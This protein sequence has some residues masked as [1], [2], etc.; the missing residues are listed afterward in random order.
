MATLVGKVGIVMKG[1]W[2]NASTYET[3]DAVS[4]SNGLYIAKQDVP[5]N[6]APTNTTY[7]QV[8][9]DLSKVLVKG[10]FNSDAEVSGNET[11]SSLKTGLTKSG[12]MFVYLLDPSEGWA[13]VQGFVSGQFKALVVLKNNHIYF[14]VSED[15]GANWTDYT[16]V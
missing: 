15:T 16:V 1:D 11:L 3:L 13:F 9:T 8:A 7:W 6:T 10:I 5:A 12:T 4:Y 2:N 14:S